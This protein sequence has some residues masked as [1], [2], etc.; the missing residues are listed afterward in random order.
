MSV[1]SRVTMGTTGNNT[2]LQPY[3]DPIISLVKDPDLNRDK[4]KSNQLLDIINGFAPDDRDVKKNCILGFQV[5]RDLEKLEMRTLQHWEFKSLHYSITLTDRIN[6]DLIKKILNN[7]VETN[8]FLANISEEINELNG[9]LKKLDIFQ[10]LSDAGTL[11]TALTLRIIDLKNKIND[12]ISVN[13]AKARLINI[14]I[15]L[16]ELVISNNKENGGNGNSNHTLL[17]E[18]TIN[19]YKS[20]IGQ[21]LKQLNNSIES[22]D[23]IGIMECIQ[24]INDVEQM[25]HSM[26][27]AAIE[28]NKDSNLAITQNETQINKEEENQEDQED[29]EDD[30]DE[31]VHPYTPGHLHAPVGHSAA[32]LKRR[33]SLSSISSVNSLTKT[34]LKEE[35]PNLLSAF[36]NA[37]KVETE[38]RDIVSSNSNDDHQQYNQ[39]RSRLSSPTPTS[40]ETTRSSSLSPELATSSASIDES[41]Y[42]LHYDDQHSDYKHNSNS[43]SRSIS[44]KKKEHDNINGKKK[45]PYFGPQLPPNFLKNPVSSRPLT[46]SIYSS[47]IPS[48]FVQTEVNGINGIRS[49]YILDNNKS[50]LTRMGIRPQVIDVPVSSSNTFHTSNVSTGDRLSQSMFLPSSKKI[51]DGKKLSNSMYVEN[52]NT[53]T[54]T[55]KNLNKLNQ[56]K[57]VNS[58]D[59]NVGKSKLNNLVSSAHEDLNQESEDFEEEED[60]EVD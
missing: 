22:N 36:Q 38:L 34:T 11:L 15:D 3:I 21:L 40:A 2:T 46:S 4:A 52:G 19:S 51:K 20:F 48:N 9:F 45:L 55:E 47:N 16:E 37:A 23:N 33:S 49:N 5:L 53:N 27:S 39:R 44:M 60:D 59:N 42:D 8:E 56:L 28:G 24:I 41:Y 50:F 12:F 54:L 1:I 58:N 30:D 13:Y 29:Q 26:S 57:A 18:S 17:N 35:M 43:L 25:F 7:C 10:Y 32:K 6:K 14:G 31:E